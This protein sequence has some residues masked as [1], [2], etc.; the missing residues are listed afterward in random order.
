[1]AALLLCAGAGACA[2]D[3]EVE[4][5]K[6]PERIRIGADKIELVLNGAGVRVRF[7]FK[8]YVAALYLPARMADGEAILRGDRPSRLWLHLL[9]DLSAEEITSAIGDALQE[10]L[11]VE[12]RVP[13]E[14]RMTQFNAIFE[15]LGDAR[16]GTQI[17]IDYLPPLGTSISVDGAEKGRIP[18]ADFKQ[19]LLRVWLGERPRDPG[20]REA[21]LGK[22]A[23]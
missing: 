3:I 22:P 21:L 23:N 2:A 4:S 19:A 5:V 8:V 12:Q 6:L 17:A 15:T 11:T 10:T 1:M 7:I 14:A 9:R 16:R 20:L 13:L 18:G